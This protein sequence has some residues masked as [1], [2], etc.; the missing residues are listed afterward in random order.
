[1][2]CYGRL[3]PDELVKSGF[4]VPMCCQDVGRVLRWVAWD[5]SPRFHGVGRILRTWQVIAP[6]SSH[7]HNLLHFTPSACSS[8]NEINPGG[9]ISAG[10]EGEMMV[11]GGEMAVGQK[12]YLTAQ[13]IEDC[14][15]QAG[16]VRQGYG[17][18]GRGVERVRPGRLEAELEGQE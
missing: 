3:R 8:M 10:D 4:I 5:F 16:R 14:N 2:P 12:C 9:E 17:Y 7:Q 15:P 1:M 18:R 11:A 13:G 6:T